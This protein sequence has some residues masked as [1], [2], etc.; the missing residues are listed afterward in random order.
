MERRRKTKSAR[1][2]LASPAKAWP[3]RRLQR[4]KAGSSGRPRNDKGDGAGFMS[5][6]KLRPPN[7]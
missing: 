7:G 2:A 5:E 6:L 1:E 3:L 4:E